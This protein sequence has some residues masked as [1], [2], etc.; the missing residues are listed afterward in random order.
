MI[1]YYWGL[2]DAHTTCLH[3]LLIL[4]TSLMATALLLGLS[5]LL[6]V[7]QWLYAAT[8]FLLLPCTVLSVALPLFFHAQ[9]TPFLQGLFLLPLL[10]FPLSLPIR[11]LQQGWSATAR[12]LGAGRQ[13][14]LRFFWLPLLKNAACQSLFLSLLFSIVQ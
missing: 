6:R 14:R 3:G 4:T 7:E 11:T 12:E 13:A 5:I 1:P 9:T 10:L 2:A 8:L